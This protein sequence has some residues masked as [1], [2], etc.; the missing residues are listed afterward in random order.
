MFRALL[1]SSSVAVDTG[2]PWLGLAIAFSRELVPWLGLFVLVAAVT[3][4][5]NIFFTISSPRIQ[6]ISNLTQPNHTRI[7]VF[8]YSE[9]AVHLARWIVAFVRFPPSLQLSHVVLPW[10]SSLL[11]GYT[12]Q[13][14]CAHVW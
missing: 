7:R 8:Q 13:T 4:A 3:P 12:R 6:K 1:L 14:S 5:R 10:R 11:Q 2:V 9:G